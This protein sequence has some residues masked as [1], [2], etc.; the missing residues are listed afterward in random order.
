MAASSQTTS[1]VKVIKYNKAR[2][3]FNYSQSIEIEREIDAQLQGAK[4]N[5]PIVGVNFSA[6]ASKERLNID[7]KSLSDRNTGEMTA[8][9]AT[10]SISL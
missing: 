4:V 7:K 10:A 2:E 5:L 8:V 6:E 9:P 1:P 3:R